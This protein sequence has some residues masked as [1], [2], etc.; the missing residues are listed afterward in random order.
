MSSQSTAAMIVTL[1]V[2]VV[3]HLILLDLLN[4]LK[5]SGSQ[6]SFWDKHL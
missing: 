1:A 2:L 4:D 5:F 6:D 3:L